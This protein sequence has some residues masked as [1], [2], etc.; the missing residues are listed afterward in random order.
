MVSELEPG[1]MAGVK[2]TT[3]NNTSKAP[4]LVTGSLFLNKVT[5]DPE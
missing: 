2:L 4:A 3:T 5:F 1:F